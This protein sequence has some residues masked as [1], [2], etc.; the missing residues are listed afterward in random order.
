MRER[1]ERSEKEGTG[2][3]ERGYACWGDWGER[4]FYGRDGLKLR[5]SNV[6]REKIQ[7]GK[8]IYVMRIDVFLYCHSP[9]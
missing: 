3:G 6:I 7:R 5:L 2:E 1:E 4:P 8:E 9:I